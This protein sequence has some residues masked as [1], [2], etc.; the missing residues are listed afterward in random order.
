MA[1]DTTYEEVVAVSG[2]GDGV[3]ACGVSRDWRRRIAVLV[4]RVDHL[5]HI[6]ELRVVLKNCAVRI[7]ISQLHN[8]TRDDTPLL[9]NKTNY[10]FGHPTICTHDLNQ[11]KSIQKQTFI[12]WIN[13]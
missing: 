6:V 1:G 11:F 3:V 13:G 5:H 7:R 10:S 4:L 9:Q 8:E 12:G 2:D